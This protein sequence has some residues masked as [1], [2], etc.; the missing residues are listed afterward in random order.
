MKNGSQ[1]RVLMENV[2]SASNNH[3][4]QCCDWFDDIGIRIPYVGTC[5]DRFD[6]KCEL[7]A[8]KYRQARR[9]APSYIGNDGTLGPTLVFPPW[10]TSFFF[11]SWLLIAMPRLIGFRIGS[12]VDYLL[13]RLPYK[14]RRLEE[15]ATLKRKLFPPRPYSGFGSG[16]R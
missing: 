8:W 1:I 3:C 7:S 4:N 15:Y 12:S 13:L 10:P 9:V 6:K 2:W 16:N 14:Q 11:P 5:G